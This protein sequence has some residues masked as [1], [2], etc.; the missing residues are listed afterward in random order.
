M[1]T[2]D[3]IPLLKTQTWTF[4]FF[5]FELSWNFYFSSWN[6]IFDIMEILQTWLQCQIRIPY[7]NLLQHLESTYQEPS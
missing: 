4:Y 5:I 7:G 2:W 3:F 1:K 6:K